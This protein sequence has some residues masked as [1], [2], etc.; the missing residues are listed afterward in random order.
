MNKRTM[1]TNVM[2]WT[3]IAGL[4]AVLTGCGSNWR[5]HEAVAISDAK[6]STRNAPD[7]V[8]GE[9]PIAEDRIYFV[10]RSFAPDYKRS[11]YPDGADHNGRTPM[12]RVGFTVMDEREAVQSARNDIY[13]QIRARLAPRNVGTA[14]QLV[15]MNID[16]GA[17][18]SPPMDTVTDEMANC[19]ATCIYYPAPNHPLYNGGKG[20]CVPC[21]SE[22]ANG[23]VVANADYMSYLPTLPGDMNMFNVGLN[24]VM[25]AMLASLSEE[26]VYFEKWHVHEGHDHSGR[27]FAE[28]R[29]EWQSY[30]CWMLCSISRA[31]YDR[32]AEE[33]RGRYTDLYEQAMEWT[34]EDRE[35]RMAW[36]NEAHA[37]ELSRQEEDRMWRREDQVIRR[38]HSITL[39]KD[40][41]PLPGRRFSIVGTP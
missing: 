40:R 2:Q 31:D 15:A 1:L 8:Q 17:L 30:K 32:I 10:G 28:G 26:R 25:P 41:H 7:W 24:S 16:S 3:A 22:V 37:M 35:R 29:D 27:P 9:M 34:A 14:G 39:D 19:N 13:D 38:D 11:A 20:V 23:Q 18:A 5:T 6:P 4:G 36:E 12:T 33:F 21:T